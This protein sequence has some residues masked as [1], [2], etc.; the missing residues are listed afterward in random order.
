MAE[1]CPT[2]RRYTE[3]GRQE[4]AV[5]CRGRPIY[6]TDFSKPLSEIIGS[7]RNDLT[8]VRGQLGDIGSGYL[9]WKEHLESIEGLLTCGLVSLYYVQEQMKEHEAKYPKTAA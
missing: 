3:R 9:A 5:E 4:L 7:L 2:C 1:T 6:G 8:R